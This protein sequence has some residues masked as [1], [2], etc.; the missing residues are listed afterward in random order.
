MKQ[1]G[2]KLLSINRKARY[3]YTTLDRL[4]CGIELCGTEV[5]SMKDGK[6]SFSDSYAKIENNELYLVGLHI[7]PYTHGNR[8]NVD[9]ERSRKLLAHKQEIKRLKR[10][11]DEKGLTLIPMSF[12]IK[13][14]IVKVDLAICKGKKI[15][16][17]RDTIK[18]RD[19]SREA[20]RELRFSKK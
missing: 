9:P 17:K 16:D 20:E 13:K 3:N 18:R 5:K 14:S 7:T 1:K 6:F 10:S 8:Y 2:R 4:E 12:Y 19:L 15:Y 11:V